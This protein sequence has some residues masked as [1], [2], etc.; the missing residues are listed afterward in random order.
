LRRPKQEGEE[1]VRIWASQHLNVE[2][3]LA[4][5]NDRWRGADYWLGAGLEGLTLEE[6]LARCEVVVVGI[7]G[8]G[9][10][11]M[12]GLAVIG[13]DKKTSE[14][15]AMVPCLGTCRSNRASPGRSPR[16]LRD[17]EQ[18]GDLTVCK[19]P[20]QDIKEAAD[21]VARKGRGPAS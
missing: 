12:L 13:R 9:L 16:R 15:L 5:H 19:E 7:D 20:T 21:I 11:D 8:G 14:W 1:S 4:L 10:D 3:G 6:L 2:I 17:F 18:D